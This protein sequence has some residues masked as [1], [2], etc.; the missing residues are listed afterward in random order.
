[1][2]NWM[3]NYRKPMKVLNTVYGLAEGCAIRTVFWLP[4]LLI[5][6]FERQPII[7]GYCISKKH[8]LSEAVKPKVLNQSFASI[9]KNEPTVPPNELTPTAVKSIRIRSAFEVHRYFSKIWAVI[10]RWKLRTKRLRRCY[11]FKKSR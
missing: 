6:G 11:F 8:S 7:C 10:Y 5:K 2:I 3:T 9:A 1:M 4:K